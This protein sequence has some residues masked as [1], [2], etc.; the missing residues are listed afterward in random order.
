MNRFLEK[1]ATQA[2]KTREVLSLHLCEMI[3]K[4]DK[5]RQ[6]IKKR[7]DEIDRHGLFSF[8]K[9]TGSTLLTLILLAVGSAI[10]LLIQWLFDSLGK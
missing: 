3:E 2:I 5:V 8:F 4:D 7:I 10:T 6:V 9:K 1:S